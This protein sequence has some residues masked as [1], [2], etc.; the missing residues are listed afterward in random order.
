VLTA[1]ASLRAHVDVWN[2]SGLV[3]TSTVERPREPRN[4]VRRFH[5]LLVQVK[6][7]RHW[8]MTSGIRPA[9]LFLAQG[10]TRQK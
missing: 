10:A 7:P 2:E 5:S 9:S 1:T 3:F 8:F 6:I 4:V